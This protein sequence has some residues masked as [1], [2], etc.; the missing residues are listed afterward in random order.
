MISQSS[1]QSQVGTERLH[2]TQI[3]IK[4]RQTHIKPS[5][6]S[7]PVCGTSH[8]PEYSHNKTSTIWLFAEVQV[9]IASTQVISS[10]FHSKRTYPLSDNAVYLLVRYHKI[11][12]CLFI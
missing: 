10:E 7:N 2:E 4:T 11:I 6:T 9:N 8:L 12:H 3:I 5:N 1:I